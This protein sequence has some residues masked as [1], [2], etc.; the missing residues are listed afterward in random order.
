MIIE[1]G[2]LSRDSLWGK[3]AVITGAGGGV[4]YEAARSLLWLGCKVVIAEIN[5]KAGG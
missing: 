1:T 4:G 2:S 5:R 3:T